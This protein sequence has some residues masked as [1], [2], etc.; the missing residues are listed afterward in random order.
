MDLARTVLALDT[1]FFV[2][3][4]FFSSRRKTRLSSDAQ[5]VDVRGELDRFV[6]QLKAT[7]N[8]KM[9][10][11]DVPTNNLVF[12]MDCPRADIWRRRI[13]PEYKATRPT[14]TGFNTD[15]FATALQ[16][17]VE[18][19]RSQGAIVLGHAH[20]EADDLAAGVSRW[21]RSNTATRLVIVT[22]DSDFL[23]LVGGCVH[24][25]TIYGDCALARLSCGDP[26]TLLLRKVLMG[27]KSDNIPAI[28]PRM[29]PKAAD[30]WLNEGV[31]AMLANDPAARKNYDKNKTL[32]DLQCA[33]ADI[34]E[35]VD[36]VVNS[37]L[38]LRTVQS[39]FAV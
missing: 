24:V 7:I 20:S 1:S 13:Y 12:L 27:D 37:A 10:D 3:H 8:R 25:H 18:P 33:P 17:V 11:Y 5:P 39:T 35:G 23:Q 22:G 34:L 30:H 4:Q 36:A 15:A 16:E 19:F 6:T 29:G 28:R 26:H 21:A 31:D 14:K 32:I 2:F 9:R 38:R